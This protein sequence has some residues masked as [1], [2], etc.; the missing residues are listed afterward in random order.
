MR[1]SA[2]AAGRRHVEPTVDKAGGCETAAMRRAGTPNEQSA[3]APTRTEA[4]RQAVVAVLA[5]GAGKRIDG[6][7]ATVRLAGRPLVYYPLAAAAQ[8]SLTAVVVAKR[9]TALPPLNVQTLLEPDEPRHPLCG[10]VAALDRLEAPVLAVGCDMPFVAPAL[11]ERLSAPASRAPDS[12]QGAVA[13]EVEGRLQPLPALYLPRQRSALERALAKGASMRET[14][15]LLR[16]DVLGTTELEGLGDP[17]L[18]LFSVNDRR[19]LQM[20]ERRL[21]RAAPA[22]Q[23]GPCT[24]ARGRGG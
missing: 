7:K 4:S 16:P 12:P 13:I 15:R 3:R 19:D 10:I 6:E 17:S 9:A 1:S 2:T 22:R 23:L 18:L 24:S 21:A 8:A 14:L 11:L 20:A 5:G